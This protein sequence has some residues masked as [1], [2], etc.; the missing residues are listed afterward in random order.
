MGEKVLERGKIV[1]SICMRFYDIY[2]LFVY[3][4]INSKSFVLYV[5]FLNN[6][7]LNFVGSEILVF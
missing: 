7:W 4:V 2:E 1:F 5:K 6:R 3:C